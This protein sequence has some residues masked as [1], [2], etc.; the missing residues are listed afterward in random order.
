[1]SE[2]LAPDDGWHVPAP[3]RRAW[4]AGS[5]PDEQAWSVEAH[6]MA[7]PA[8][9]NDVSIEVAASP[10]EALIEDVRGRLHALP[11]QAPLRPAHPARR[12][13]ALLGLRQVGLAWGLVLLTFLAGATVLDLLSRTDLV[14]ATNPVG[15]LAWFAAGGSWVAAVA[16]VLPV[17]GVAL[18]WGPGLDPAHE[19]VAATPVAGLRL[20]LWRTTGVLLTAFPAA[21]MV[22]VFVALIRPAGVGSLHLT[23]WILPSL[24]LTLLTLA[25]GSLVGT[26]PA[27]AAVTAVWFL[28][29]LAPLGAGTTP[30]L[31]AAIPSR[32]W[33][34]CA[35]AGA[36]VLVLRHDRLG[37]LLIP[38]S[39]GG[40]A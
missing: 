21:L 25:A 24:G 38:V 37:R 3:L 10:I 29:A 34:V 40:P 11:S 23:G 28:G 5:V 6:L 8:C 4:V 30:L 36:G 15:A 19:I 33:A 39:F 1:M 31:L 32:L 17:L 7:C 13:R 9:R 12:V 20:V 2:I 27:A 35:A 14:G 22:Q 26:A 18:A 16:P